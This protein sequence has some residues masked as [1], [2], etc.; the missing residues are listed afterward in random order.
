MGGRFSAS[1]VDKPVLPP[2]PT[3]ERSPLLPNPSPVSPNNET[4]V[5]GDSCPS[6]DFDYKRTF[7]DEVKT[8]SRYTLPVFG[9]A[10]RSVFGTGR[11]LIHI[12]RTHMLEVQRTAHSIS[13]F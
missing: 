9:Y 6:H 2:G 7:F 8:L 13:P 10:S 5:E 12:Y 11:S 4:Y 3:N 1:R